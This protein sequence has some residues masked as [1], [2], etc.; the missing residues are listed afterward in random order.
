MCI[1]DPLSLETR[2]QYTKRLE[3]MLGMCIQYE[4]ENARRGHMGSLPLNVTLSSLI[5]V[6]MLRNSLDH[7]AAP[8]ALAIYTTI[9][10]SS[11]LHHNVA[12]GPILAANYLGVLLICT[13]YRTKKK[14]REKDRETCNI[15][16]S[17][18]HL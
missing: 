11:Q 10:S 18:S 3:H 13:M 1:H 5:V 8:P 15:S 16:K 9:S 4:N 12:N 7:A 14:E 6:C 2:E 17:T